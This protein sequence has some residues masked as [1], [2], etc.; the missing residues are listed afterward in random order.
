MGEAV[1]ASTPS[2]AAQEATDHHAM[3]LKRITF[4]NTVVA[5]DQ[6]Q[7]A[8]APLAAH[9]FIAAWASRDQDTSLEGV[10]AQRFNTMR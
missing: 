6:W 8:V 2:T 3:W 4:L 9:G 1:I 7:P 5:K 10:Y